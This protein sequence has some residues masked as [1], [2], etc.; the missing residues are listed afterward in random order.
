MISIEKEAKTVEDA[1]QAGLEQLAVTKDEV[2]IEIL[3]EGGLF[4]KA[5]VKLTVK[6][7]PKE[8]LCEYVEGL[9]ERMGV[10]CYVDVV[11]NDKG[12]YVDIS[13]KDSAI[14]IGYRGEVL[15][16]IQY[17]STIRLN[18]QDKNY[19]HLT[20]DVEGYRGRRAETLKQLALRLAD[21]A[22]RSG[23]PQELEPMNTSDRKIIHEA[24]ANDDRVRTESTGD[25]P[26]RHVTIIP[27]E[28]PL[29][30]GTSK[31]FK[32]SGVKTRSFGNKKRRF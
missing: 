4:S 15:D 1:I 13:G 26:N 3:K 32:T 10:D 17:I 22:D 9:L 18:K 16:A 8:E 5:K 23:I 20:F 25:E 24:L 2:E 6:S 30:F 12:Y 19:T 28:K 7:T 21:K 14:V 27:K 11:E 29:T 31:E